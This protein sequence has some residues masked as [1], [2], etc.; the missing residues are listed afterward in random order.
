MKDIAPECQ[1][2][3]WP[4]RTFVTGNKTSPAGRKERAHVRWIPKLEFEQVFIATDTYCVNF[5]GGKGNA[6]RSEVLT[7]LGSTIPPNSAQIPLNTNFI[8]VGGAKTLVKTKSGS[9]GTTTVT[10]F[11]DRAKFTRAAMSVSFDWSGMEEPSD[12]NDYLLKAN[13]CWPSAIVPQDPG[14]VLLTD[15]SWYKTNSAGKKAAPTATA[16]AQ[17]PDQEVLK[18][19]GPMSSAL[20]MASALMSMVLPHAAKE[21]R[22]V[23]IRRWV[24]YHYRPEDENAN[25]AMSGVDGP[26]IPQITEAIPTLV[27]SVI[28]PQVA[29]PA[30]Q[31]P[32]VEA[33][34]PV[35]TAFP[36]V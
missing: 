23:D 26:I 11:Y 31:R 15:D 14:Y 3:P 22:Q 21:K 18:A 12:E 1:A 36:R 34:M 6:Q 28:K 5:D 17:K 10:T 24:D 20:S 16:Y 13:P 19:A 32:V 35:V 8:D 33:D 30:G 4:L 25:A 27:T 2:V 9:D 29:Q 7:Q